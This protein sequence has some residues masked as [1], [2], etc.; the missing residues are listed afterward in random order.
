[1]SGS[2]K[3]KVLFLCTGNSCRSQMAEGYARALK[4][5]LIEPFSAGVM[6][7]GVHP[8]AVKVMGEDGVDISGQTSQVLD[9]FIEVEFNYVITLCG[10]AAANCPFFPG[11]VKRIHHPFDDPPSLAVTARNQEEALSHFRRVRDEIKAY[12]L[13]MPANLDLE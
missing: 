13:G 1:M 3:L 5:D 12:I 11:A 8:N 2:S 7:A 6:A 10:H 4:G 9:E